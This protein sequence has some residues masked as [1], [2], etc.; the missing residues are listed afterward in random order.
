MNTTILGKLGGLI[1]ACLSLVAN[2]RAA[3]SIDISGVQNGQSTPVSIGSAIVGDARPSKTF[4]VKNLGRS[5]LTLGAVTIPSGFILSQ[6][7]ATTVAPGKQ[8]TFTIA[9]ETVK[10][11]T[12]SGVVSIPNNDRTKNPFRFPVEG[13]V[14]VRATIPDI[15]VVGVVNHQST[16][17]SLGTAMVGGVR[18][19]ATFVVRNTGARTL[20]ISKTTVPAGFALLRSPAGSVAPGQQTS[21]SIELSTA[22]PGTFAGKVAITSNDPDENPFD[23]PVQGVVKAIEGKPE[24]TVLVNGKPYPSNANGEFKTWVYRGQ[25]TGNPLIV[26]LRN[27]GKGNLVISDWKLS[28]GFVSNPAQPGTLRPGASVDVKILPSTAT[29]PVRT[30]A[31]TFRTNDEDE[32]SFTVRLR[33]IVFEPIETNL[34]SNAISTF[35]DGQV[36]IYS[37]SKMYYSIE[38]ANGPMSWG[39]AYVIRTYDGTGRL[40]SRLNYDSLLRK[41]V[42]F[43]NGQVTVDNWTNVSVEMR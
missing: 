42:V 32:P 31:L 7:P 14:K 17:V 21:F 40:V 1:V 23:F 6:S 3:S 27:E 19:T 33:G 5:N 34:W 38:P 36:T 26:T 18:P 43:Q 11:G 13:T 24:I 41:V 4:T 10:A 2:A 22:T 9:L 35:P 12:P 8:T 16:P 39:G 20:T 37:S 15:D 29:L 28:T 25:G 30:G